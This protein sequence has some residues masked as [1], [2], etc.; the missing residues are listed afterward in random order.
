M[1]ISD[2]LIFIKIKLCKYYVPIIFNFKTL[3]QVLRIPFPN[4][5]MPL[6]YFMN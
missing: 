4:V 3:T 5:N 1:K 6:H 2:K